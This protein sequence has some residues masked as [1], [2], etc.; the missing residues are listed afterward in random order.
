MSP[1]AGWIRGSPTG[2]RQRS[3]RAAATRSGAVLRS[4]WPVRRGHLA[5][6][7]LLAPVPPSQAGPRVGGGAALSRTRGRARAV[8]RSVSLRRDRHDAVQEAAVARAHHGDRRH[9]SG[10]LH[11]SPLRRADLAGDPLFSALVG[12]GV[13][14]LMGS[15][16][17]YY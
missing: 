14:T 5:E 9:R 1:T 16:A 6:A 11:P 2:E 15:V 10:P 13:G 3:R 8:D 7:S 4:A 12:T 17:G